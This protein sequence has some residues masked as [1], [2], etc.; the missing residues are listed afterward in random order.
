MKLKSSSS[1]EEGCLK[2]CE[3]YGYEQWLKSLALLIEP[4]SESLTADKIRGNIVRAIKKIVI[5]FIRLELKVISDVQNKVKSPVLLRVFNR[6]KTTQMVFDAI[7]RKVN[8][9]SFIF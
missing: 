8:L 6:P 2:Y 1:F 9:K 7:R 3:R 5:M 4:K